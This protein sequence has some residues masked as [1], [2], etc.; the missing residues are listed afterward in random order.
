MTILT[1]DK[2]ENATEMNKNKNFNFNFS[3]K[4][5]VKNRKPDDGCGNAERRFGVCLAR[6]SGR[7]RED[8]NDAKP[9]HVGGGLLQNSGRN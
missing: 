6:A 8:E 5:P 2:F 7:T 1:I 4:S 3:D 9:W